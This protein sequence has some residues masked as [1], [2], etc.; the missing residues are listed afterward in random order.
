[1]KDVFDSLWMKSLAV[2]ALIILI[3]CCG[4]SSPKSRH[5]DIAGCYVTQSGT[6]AVGSIEAQSAPEGV[7]SAMVKYTDDTSWFSD[8]KKHTISILLTGTNSTVHADAIVSNI[9]RAFTRTAPILEYGYPQIST[10]L[11]AAV[12]A[13]P[14]GGAAAK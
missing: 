14:T 5:L 7:E 3:L 2:M 8:Q 10:N 6:F 13:M 1:M 4:C 9:C 12:P 11:T